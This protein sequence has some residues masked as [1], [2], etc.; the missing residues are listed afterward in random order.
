MHPQHGHLGSIPAH[1]GF[2]I[3]CDSRAGSSPS[4]SVFL[5]VIISPILYIHLLPAANWPAVAADSILSHCNDCQIHSG[6]KVPCID[7][8]QIYTK[9]SHF[10]LHYPPLYFPPSVQPLCSN[11]WYSD[12][13]TTFI[14]N[15]TGLM[16]EGPHS[17]H[18]QHQLTYLMWP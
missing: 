11:E 8:H 3:K 18:P 5:S 14:S 12:N 17:S 6:H 1:I 10:P 16:T 9:V 15:S 7:P 2:V 4:T 13:H